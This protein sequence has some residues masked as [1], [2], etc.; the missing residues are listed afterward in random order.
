MDGFGNTHNNHNI[1][2]RIEG[3]SIHNHDTWFICGAVRG[4]VITI[5]NNVVTMMVISLV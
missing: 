4:D 3:E 2:D 1:I 5:R